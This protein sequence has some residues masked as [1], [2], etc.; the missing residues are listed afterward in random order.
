V[1]TEISNARID[2]IRSAGTVEYHGM[3]SQARIQSTSLVK[4]ERRVLGDT[5]TYDLSV[6]GGLR[7]GYQEELAGFEYAPFTLERNRSTEQLTSTEQG[8]MFSLSVI[9]ETIRQVPKRTM[10]EGE[11][12]EK[13]YLA[14][15]EFFPPT[16]GL[17]FAVQTLQVYDVPYDVLLITI[18]SDLLKYKVAEEG[19][20]NGTVNARYKAVLVYSPAEDLLFQA[21]AKFMAIH[22]EELIRFENLQFLTD[23]TG[24]KPLFPLIDVSQ[25]LG[26]VQKP[27]EL[28]K[29]GSLPMWA[30]Q[31]TRVFDVV[32]TAAM[33]VAEQSTNPAPSVGVGGS[34]WRSIRETA[35]WLSE[36]AGPQAARDFLRSFKVMDDNFSK[37]LAD[38]AKY[39][40]ELNTMALDVASTALTVS[41]AF[42]MLPPPVAFL[43]GVAGTA[44]TLYYMQNK[45]AQIG[46]DIMDLMKG[47]GKLAPFP[48]GPPKPTPPQPEPPPPVEVKKP[49]KGGPDLADIFLIA[50][51]G[52]AAVGVGYYVATAMGG[53]QI[54][55]DPGERIC[56][57][58]EMGLGKWICC[59]ESRPLLGSN[60]RCYTWF[61]AP[62]GVTTILCRPGRCVDTK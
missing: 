51:L 40:S 1:E 60:G 15:S 8:V 14:L 39:R 9:N 54:C 13:I 56:N 49:P 24:E 23:E 28:K 6:V 48:P 62:S 41:T 2:H 7:I 12:E 30:V 33:A 21:A 11:W 46:Q 44:L 36:H 31:S 61:E 27:L 3:E 20:D 10:R 50:G 38:L 57:G 47:P 42:V 4:S 32:N 53:K 58:Y 26:F 19:K 17:K 59:P 45:F 29:E 16:L 18:E 35:H 22:E 25:Y 52:V 55:C 34:L 43:V 5:I 37:W